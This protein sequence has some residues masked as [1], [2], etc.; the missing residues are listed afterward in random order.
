MT[1]SVPFMKAT[2]VVAPKK[3]SKD[4]P[5]LEEAIEE[6]DDGDL[7]EAAEVDDD[8]MDIKGDKYIKQPKAKPASKK[9]ASKKT[10]DADGDDEEDDVKP[11]K[12]KGKGKGKGKAA[13][14]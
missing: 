3:S 8:D 11:A 12:G 6:E 10:A 9:K 13:K 14:K 2:N 7:P 5:D 1:H 4:V